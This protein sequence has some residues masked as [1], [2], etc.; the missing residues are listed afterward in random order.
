MPHSKKT[1][2][3]VSWSKY[4]FVDFPI[5]VIIRD[6]YTCVLTGFQDPSHPATDGNI[7][8]VYL[9]ASHILRR[10]IGKFDKDPKSD[11]VGRL[12]KSLH[13]AYGASFT[14]HPVQVRYYDV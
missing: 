3:D 9:Q 13:L 6:G 1:Y 12:S 11:S 4:R 5:K 2:V 10:A 14:L 7:P 8:S